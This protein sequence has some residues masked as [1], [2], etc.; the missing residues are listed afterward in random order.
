M[1]IT[2][3]LFLSHHFI[4]GADNLFLEFYRFTGEINCVPGWTIP[5]VSFIPDLDDEI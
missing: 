1:S 2:V 3:I 5:K 4:L